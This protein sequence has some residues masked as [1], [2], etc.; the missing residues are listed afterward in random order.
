MS[1]FSQYPIFFKSLKWMIFLGIALVIISNVYI[2]LMTNPYLYADETQVPSAYTGVIL[3][4]WVAPDGR[5]SDMLEDRVLTGLRL[6]RQGRVKKLLLSGDHGQVGYDEVN[7]MRRYLLKAGVP[8]EDLFMD[9]AGFKTY[10]SFYRARDVFQ[11]KDALVITQGFHL[12]RSVYTAQT[13][14]LKAFGVEA[15]HNTNYTHRSLIRANL[16]EVLARTKAMIE[17]HILRFPPKYLGEVIPIIGDGRK[18]WD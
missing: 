15:G 4:A 6:Y 8:P 17:L 9:H 7:A 12:A 1:F 18:S 16:R 3:G 14:G 2:Y 11:V 10:D 13:F 5:L